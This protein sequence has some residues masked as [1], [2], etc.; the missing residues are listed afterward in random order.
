MASRKRKLKEE[1][2]KRAQQAGSLIAIY[3][4]QH[5]RRA[6]RI[7][8]EREKSQSDMPDNPSARWHLE[9]KNIQ[10]NL[11]TGGGLELTRV[12]A[13]REAITVARQIPQK[14]RRV[15][16][17]VGRGD[18]LGCGLSIALWGVGDFMLC[19]R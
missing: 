19:E 18:G 12:I 3:I 13:G 15:R 9:L 7:C 2:P 8:K 10:Q 6:G 16:V 4:Y 1:S 11:N 14:E 5:H 17:W